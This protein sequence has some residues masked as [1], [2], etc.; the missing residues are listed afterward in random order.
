MIV[1]V[2][3]SKFIF[4][5]LHNNLNFS[6]ATFVYLDNSKSKSMLI[7]LGEEIPEDQLLPETYRIDIFDMKTPLPPKTTLTREELHQILFEYGIGRCYEDTVIPILR[8]V[9]FILGAS[10]FNKQFASPK[11]AFE[12]AAKRGGAGMVVMDKTEL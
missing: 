11:D 3:P 4:N 2:Y 8:P 12:K 1:D 5:S 9:V 6:I 10:R 7:A